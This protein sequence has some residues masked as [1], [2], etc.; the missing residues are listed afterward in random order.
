MRNSREVND[1]RPRTA[2]ILTA[3]LAAGVAGGQLLLSNEQIENVLRSETAPYR[4][5]DGEWVTSVPGSSAE[6]WAVGDSGPGGDDPVARLIERADPDRLL[7]LGDVYTHGTPSEFRDWATAWGALAPR[8]APTPGNHD[9]PESTEGYDPYWQRETGRLPPTYYEFQAGGWQILSLN[10]E[11]EKQDAQAAWLRER[12]ASGGTCRIA[13][14]HRPRWSAG[15]H[16]DDPAAETLWN[17]ARGRVAIVLNGHEHNMQQLGPIDGTTQ[18]ISGAG[19]F[20]HTTPSAEDPRLGYGDGV[21]YGALRLRLTPGRAKWA[22]V[23]SDGA[24]L[25]SGSVHCAQ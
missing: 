24:L 19:G 20:S 11:H 21:H 23:A 14:W 9:W 25:R 3:V 8:M 17:A 16:G 18:F 4:P 1:V 15:P 12:A 5:P 6:V 22:F 13:F 7:Y 2:L 10:S